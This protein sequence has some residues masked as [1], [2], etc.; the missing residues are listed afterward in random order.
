MEQRSAPEQF[1]NTSEHDAHRL[2][3]G[4]I[5]TA[6]LLV[7]LL[8]IGLAI[9]D[10]RG[11]LE[12]VTDAS[13]GWVVLAIALEV[14]SC[15]G[16]V[17]AVRLVLRR[18]PAREVRRL[19]W[20]EQAFGAVV[21]VG[22]AGGLAVGAWAMR[23]WGIE[24]SRIVNRSVVIF[25]LTSAVNALVLVLA[26]FGITLGIGGHAPNLAYA[27]VPGVLALL[28][29]IFA[30]LLPRFRPRED[31]SGRIAAALRKSADFLSDTEA[32]AFQLDWRLIG[33][34]GYLVFDIAMLWVCMRAVGVNPPLLALV[35]GYQIGYLANLLPVPGGVGVLEGGL[36]GALLLYGFHAGPAA[37]AVVIY[38]A[39]ALWVPTVGGIY[40]F[41]R[42]RRV[43]AAG[44][45]S[46][47]GQGVAAPSAQPQPTAT[48]RPQPT[49][50]A[51]PQPTA[52]PHPQPTATARPQPM[53]AARQ[54]S[55]STQ[56]NLTPEASTQAAGPSVPRPRTAERE[57][58]VEPSRRAPRRAVRDA[59]A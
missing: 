41:A 12:R 26:S 43:V 18:G 33:T 27:L 25:L 50:S 53:A 9:P 36:L 5:W 15:L 2:R 59:A 44:P 17:A 10:L 56:P 42:L 49:A 24:W 8:G 54:A 51:Q 48:A 52:A 28:A 38:H 29:L 40:G 47:R 35:M 14:A 23:A 57:R 1:T 58:N 30:M 34:A 6:A 11:V 16:Y 13:P 4:V 39:I 7:L 31:R 32:I 20:A 22:G 46:Q 45:P 3:N 19:A 55:H 21:P 37:A